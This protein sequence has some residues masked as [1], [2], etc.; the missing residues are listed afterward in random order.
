LKV[1][2]EAFRGK[3]SWGQGFNYV[4]AWAKGSFVLRVVSGEDLDSSGLVPS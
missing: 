1:L 3:K 2:L 4:I